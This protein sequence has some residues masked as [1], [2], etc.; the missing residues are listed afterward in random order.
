MLNEVDVLLARII[1]RIKNA[2]IKRGKMFVA[3]D[4]HAYAL[5]Q[6]LK[7]WHMID[8]TFH[9]TEGTLKGKMYIVSIP[10]RTEN[11]LIYIKTKDNEI[12]YRR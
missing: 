7:D 10:F 9:G 5:L 6:M 1:E 12:V 3:V 4:E 2:P 11:G 8:F